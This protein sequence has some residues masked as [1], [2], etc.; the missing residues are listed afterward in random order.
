MKSLQEYVELVYKAN[1]TLEEMISFFPKTE[2]DVKTLIAY[3][4]QSTINLKAEVLSISPSTR[5]FENTIRQFDCI[6]FQQVLVGNILYLLTNVIT[7][8]KLSTQLKESLKELLTFASTLN[9]DQK[10]YQ[11]FQEYMDNG[12]KQE[13]TILNN[14]S[15]Y[16]IMELQAFFKRK[17]FN[18]KKEE[19]DQIRHCLNEQEILSKKFE[20]NVSDDNKTLSA[21]TEELKGL[22]QAFIHTLKKNS[23]GECILT[24]DFPTYAEIISHCDSEEIRK[25]CY[26]LYNERGYP[27]NA[28]IL[29]K[30]HTISEQLAKL[31]GFPNFSCYDIS[32]AM[33]KTPEAVKCFYKRISTGIQ[34]KETSEIKL[35]LSSIDSKLYT[36][37]DGKIYPWS[38]HYLMK[39][40]ESKYLKVDDRE[41]A[42]YFE[43]EKT[44]N[45]IFSIYQTFLS[46]KFSIVKPVWIWHEDVMT[47]KVENNDGKVLYG[48]VFLDLYP[49]PHKYTHG[50]CSPIKNG[51][52]K[53]G[54]L[55][56][57]FTSIIVNLPKPTN[58]LPALWKF[59]D[60]NTFFHEFGHAIHTIL[61]KTEMYK[62][63]GF[64]VKDDFIETP[65]QMFEKWISDKDVI[66]SLSSN[67]LTGKHMP[68]EMIDKLLTISKG[69]IG[70]IG[71]GTMCRLSLIHI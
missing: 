55:Y 35:L 59:N 31:C 6:Y 71:L 65:S 14:E 39:Q 16:F 66:R 43:A 13:A 2:Q 69:Y 63:S 48:Y 12:F 32:K 53:N 36:D 3:C 61:S 21:K 49:R 37:K 68:D 8:P 45:G 62:F 23:D 25:K 1:I 7:E 56:P 10:I 20:N 57:T 24:L 28:S 46:L 19:F 47:I 67:Y 22:S 58:D 4:I 60:V 51:I 70:I 41:V 38:M 54:I 34:K 42:N 11:S 27:S 17:G 52:K 44:L 15:K 33:A 5:T 26:L 18:L 30:M 9:Y 29:E 40:Y 50:M 64:N